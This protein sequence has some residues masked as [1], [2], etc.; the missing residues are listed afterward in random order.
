MMMIFDRNILDEEVRCII[1][2]LDT[3]GNGSV[4]L[5]EFTNALR[6]Q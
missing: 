3:D 1:A 4:S 2:F 6:Q 5:E